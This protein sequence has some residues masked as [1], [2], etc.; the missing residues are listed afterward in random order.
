VANCSDAPAKLPLALKFAE[1]NASRD[2]ACT[3]PE[4]RPQQEQE[5]RIT[6]NDSRANSLMDLFQIGAR[7][8]LF[9]M[10]IAKTAGMSMRLYLGGQ[11]HPYEVCPAA[12]WRDVLGR[13]NELRTFRLVRGH[14]QYNLRDLVAEEARMLVMLRDPLRRTISALRH[15]QRDPA[16]HPD[17]RIAKDLT[18]HQMLRHSGL[19]D[20][21]RNVQASFLCASAPTADV[22]AF[23]ERE[24][25]DNPDADP[26]DLEEPP[27]LQFAKDRLASIDFVGITED[28]GALVTTMARAM[29][30]HPP[31]YFPFINEDPRRADPLEG[32]TDE[33]IAILREHNDVDLPLY[34]FAKQLM[35]RRSFERRMHELTQSGVYQTPQGSFAIDVADIVPGSGWYE[36]EKDSSTS[37]RWTGPGRYFTVEVPL[38]RDASYRLSMTFGSARPLDPGDFAAEVN[39][40][41]VDFELQPEGGGY[42]CELAIPQA[43]LAR[44]GGF[45]HIRFDTHETVQPSAQDLRPLG[46]SVRRIVFECLET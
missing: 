2:E 21:Q 15:L 3:Q 36:P 24:L 33:D 9:F 35:A 13:E 8:P 32:L 44:S 41:P 23:L 34:E 14:F 27:E 42:R 26:A 43:L 29:N 6:S 40:V 17:H 10:H 30:Y 1:G 19:M 37:W 46:V 25:P 18:L 16:F 12:E 45:C 20:K 31:L 11:Y 38:R 5:R 22:I 4:V 39:D 28:I 7:E